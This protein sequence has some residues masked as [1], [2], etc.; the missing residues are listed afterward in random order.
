[1]EA[2]QEQQGQPTAG[3]S[4]QSAPTSPPPPAPAPAPRTDDDQK[5]PPP[6]APAQAKDKVPQQPNA[7]ASSS[8][9]TQTVGQQPRQPQ[10]LQQREP[11]LRIRVLAVEKR[12]KELNVRLDA[13][14]STVPQS[15]TFV[16]R[17]APILT[18]F[19]AFSVVATDE[20]RSFQAFTLPTFPALV[21]R[22]DILCPLSVCTR[23]F[24]NSRF[25]P[26]ATTHLREPTLA[27]SS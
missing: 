23:T 6:Q 14:V 3:P 12:G 22:A 17:R 26:P 4:Q 25:P 18:L 21:S 2:Q 13:A 9:A 24:S 10:Q 5:Q 7:A 16:L 8:S 27:A 20:P 19:T 1:M 15:K 11:L